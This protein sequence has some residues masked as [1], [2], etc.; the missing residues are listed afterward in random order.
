MKPLYGSL[1]ISTLWASSLMAQPM[2]S[3]II[4]QDAVNS[5]LTAIGSVSGHT[6]VNGSDCTWTV[7]N[8]RIAITNGGADC[9]ADTS[10]RAGLINYSSAVKGKVSVTYDDTKNRVLVKISKASLEIYMNLFGTRMHLTDIDVSNYY[11]QEF[12]FPGPQLAQYSVPM[13]LP[14]GTKKTITVKQKPLI[15]SLADESIIVG[16]DLNISE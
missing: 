5:F 3:M 14:D 4:R 13:T 7:D 10:A 2:V 8:P 11:K 15:L 9:F 6:T 16:S 1:L 12:Q